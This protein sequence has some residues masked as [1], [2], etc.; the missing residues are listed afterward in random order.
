MNTEE[1]EKTLLGALLAHNRLPPDQRLDSDHGCKNEAGALLVEILASIAK[2][3]AEVDRVPI[4]ASR[5][6]ETLNQRDAKRYE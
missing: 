1:K 3:P 6:A 4:V 5:L 2:Q